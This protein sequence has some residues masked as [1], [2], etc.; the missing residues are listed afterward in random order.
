MK[1]ISKNGD[2]FNLSDSELFDE[3]IERRVIDCLAEFA[4]GAGHELNNPLAIISGLAQNLLKTENDPQKRLAYASIIAQTS[5]AYEMIADVRAF[6]R[7]PLPEIKKFGLE[8]FFNDWT[9]REILRVEKKK[10]EIQVDLSCEIEDLEIETDMSMLSSILDALGKNAFEIIEPS[11]G[12]LFFFCRLC[13]D[14]TEV[15][16]ERQECAN[17]NSEFL[18]HSN[19]KDQNARRFLEIGVE[20]NGANISE[21]DL[22][23]MFAPFYS[24][25]QAGRGLGFGLSKAWRYAEV[26]GIQLVCTR[27]RRFSSG[28]RWATIIPLSCVEDV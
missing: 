7:P 26:L 2:A 1:D 17:I 4:A 23:Y 11:S 10:V 28:L 3:A 12:K 20:N 25:R 5:R 6:A 24:G 15:E 13:D 8:S 16:E 14:I 27:S 9:R 19:E 22:K 18:D 21:Q